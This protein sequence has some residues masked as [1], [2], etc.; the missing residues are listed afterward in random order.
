MPAD[1][2]LPQRCGPG[3]T[4]VAEG[5]LVRAALCWGKGNYYNQLAALP[6]GVAPEEGGGAADRRRAMGV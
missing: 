6:A 3:F 2:L 1:V 4:E 5:P